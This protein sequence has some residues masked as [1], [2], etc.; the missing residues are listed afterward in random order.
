M[1]INGLQSLN[2][3]NNRKQ[4][5]QALGYDFQMKAILIPLHEVLSNDERSTCRIE[6]VNAITEAA[7]EQ[8]NPIECVNIAGSSSC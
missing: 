1:Y 5:R 7:G 2:Y 4:P 3:I 6:L 8:P